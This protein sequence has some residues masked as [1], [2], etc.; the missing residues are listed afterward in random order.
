MKLSKK[1]N[2]NFPTHKK[3]KNISRGSLIQKRVIIGH[4]VIEF[5][6]TNGLETKKNKLRINILK[7]DCKGKKK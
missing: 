4:F 1:E 2:K 7:S 3:K 5:K 6:Q